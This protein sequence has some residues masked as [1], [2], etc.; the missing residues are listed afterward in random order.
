MLDNG[1]DNYKR[2]L[3]GDI[4]AIGEIIQEY[5]AG[6]EYFLITIVNNEDA[7]EEITQDTFCYL[8]IK[9]PKF[10]EK[11]SFK[12]WLYTIGKNRAYRYL[13]K[14]QKYISLDENSES[15][16]SD[17]RMLLEEKYFSDTEKLNILD[18]IGKLKKEYKE[19]L[20]LTYF[21][22][23]SNKECAEILGKKV[24]NIESLLYR[25]RL[26]LKK[27]LQEEGYTDENQR[28]NDS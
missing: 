7:A 2:F 1:A 8:F 22:N 13:K 18:V 28:K 10:K 3:K 9:K 21:E 23:L 5:R 26:A 24:H 14:A 25:A 19:I 12:T 11:S 6:L 16:I 17:E 15:F 4:D 20:W 27:I